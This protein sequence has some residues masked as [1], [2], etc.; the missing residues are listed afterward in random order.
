MVLERESSTRVHFNALIEMLGREPALPDAALL[1]ARYGVPVFPCVPGTKRPIVR[2]GFHEA[3]TDVR[4]VEAWWRRWPD[5]N[6]AVPTG[7]ASGV[8]VVDVDRHPERDGLVGFRRARDAGLLAGWSAL[9]TTPSTGLHVYFP[10]D[11][12]RPQR[13]WQAASAH[14]DFRGDGG[15]VLVPPSR[16]TYP[17]GSSGKYA[18]SAK[19]VAA[20]LPVDAA[21][22]REFLVPSR[23]PR[24]PFPIGRGVQGRGASDQ[25]RADWVAARPEGERNAGLFYMACRM[26]EDGIPL[27]ETLSVLAPGAERAGLGVQEIT[28]TV[29]SAYRQEGPRQADSMTTRTQAS[30]SL[31]EQLPRVAASS[32]RVIA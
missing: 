29:E 22:L 18:L 27:A 25:R 2:G 15:Y 4:Q 26:M 28:R 3:T 12:E 9:V 24:R 6:L 20:T 31:G 21:A 19:G 8:D 32:G 23:S 16:V 10:A 14:I 17:D 13:S 11:A 5:A 7:A 30:P 1:L